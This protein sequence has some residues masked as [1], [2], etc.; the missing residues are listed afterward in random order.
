M[1]AEKPSLKFIVNKPKKSI[2]IGTDPRTKF[3]IVFAAVDR[4]LVPNCSAAM[5]TNIAQYPVPVP[6]RKHIS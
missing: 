1:S 2:M 4:M 6:K 3:G 5:V